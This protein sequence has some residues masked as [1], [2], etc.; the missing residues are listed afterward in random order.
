MA[1]VELSDRSPVQM[2]DWP[3]GLHYSWASAGP[4]AHAIIHLFSRERRP[5]AHA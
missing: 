4:D 5:L 2:K 1:R 3:T